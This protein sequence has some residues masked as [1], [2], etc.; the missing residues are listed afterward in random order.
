MDLKLLVDVIIDQMCSL[1]KRIKIK[2]VHNKKMLC[3]NDSSFNR[4][5]VII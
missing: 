5:D 1:F 4:H 3:L 2:C